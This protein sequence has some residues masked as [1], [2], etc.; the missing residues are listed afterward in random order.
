MLEEVAFVNYGI[1]DLGSNTV[2]LSLYRVLPEGDYDLLFSKK[3]MAGLVNYIS[4]GVLSQE[5]IHRA[6]SILEKFRELLRHF[7]VENFYVFAT[8]PLR[9]IRNS[10]EAVHTIRKKTGLDVD[11]LSGDLEAELGYYGALRTLN[12]KDGALFDIGGGSTEIVEVRA[13]KILRAQSLPLGSLNLFKACVSRIWPKPKELE[14]MRKIVRR[15]LAEA[16]LP[17]ERVDRVCG[18]GGTARALLKIANTWY[19]RPELERRMTPKDLHQLNK[20]LQKQSGEVRQL[21]LNHCP[22]RLHTILPGAL[23]MDT[24]TKSLCREELYISRTGVREGYLYHKVLHRT[25]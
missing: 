23:L 13:G 19:G 11:V 20:E 9:N 8:A 6:C 25:E 18:V 7:G 2:R 17:Q 5:G 3:E 10:E 1:V 14:E 16:N 21:V 12:L 24:V 4:G 22:D 15:T